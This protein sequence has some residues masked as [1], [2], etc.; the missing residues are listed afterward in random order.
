MGCV[1]GW[2][3]V[4]VKMGSLAKRTKRR[5]EEVCCLQWWI[6]IG[7]LRCCW[8][9]SS[10]GDDSIMGYVDGA[11]GDEAARSP[12]GT[13]AHVAGSV[14]LSGRPPT[15]GSRGSDHIYS[16]PLLH[17]IVYTLLWKLILSYAVSIP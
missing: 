4:R 7:V 10:L 8:R 1:C 12:M 5:D 9:E 14:L 15:C 2:I 6:G 3:R 17:C 13:T 16:P 11:V